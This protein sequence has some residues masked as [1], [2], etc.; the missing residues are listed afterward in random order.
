ME[1][2]GFTLDRFQEEAIGHLENDRSVLVAA[3]TGTGKTVV[4][5]WAVDEALRTGRRVIY[6]APIKALS[7]QKFRDYGRLHGTENVGLVTGDLVINRD[8]PC[9]VMTTEILRNM[10]LGGDD[11]EDLFAVVLDEVHFLDDR[12]RGT[13]WEEVLIYLPQRVLIVAL[14]A[15]LPNLDD[16]SRW[17]SYVRG[18]PTEVVIENERAVPLAFHVVTHGRDLMSLDEFD[19][20]ARRQQQN[21]RRE[22]DRRGSGRGRGRGR[23]QR[24]DRK[25]RKR[26]RGP[27]THPTEA[28]AHVRDRG[29]FPTLYFVF[30]RKDAERFAKSL[31]WRYRAEL[32]DQDEI[33][34]VDA[35]IATET[36]GEKLDPAMHDMYRRGIAFHH[37]GLHVHLK[38]LV[39]E[40][41]EQRLIK[42]LFCTS[43]FALGI[44][45][46]ARSVVF[47]GLHK[48]DGES[49]KPLPTRGFMQKA[50][51]AGRRGLDE[52]GH[53]VI[54]VDADD[55]DEARPL[56]KRYRSGR[57][58]PVRSR[59]S[60]SWNSIVALLERHDLD[61]IREVVD[62]SFL[63]WHRR[64]KAAEQVVTA[65]ELEST[66][67]G[68]KPSKR[69]LK[70]ARR[71]RRRAE[72]AED[73][74]W[75]EFLRK[76]DFLVEIG[77]LGP[78]HEFRAGARALR[79]LQIAELF[80][81]ELIL[82][83]VFHDLDNPTLFGLLCALTNDVPRAVT[84]DARLDRKDREL[85]LRV[86]PIRMGAAV[87]GGERIARQPVTW[88]AELIPVG[89]AWAD[90]WEFERVMT[91]VMSESDWSGALINGFRRAKDLL[92]QLRD[93]FEDDPTMNDRLRELHK[94]VARD[95]VQ[96]VG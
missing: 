92:G 9:L 93:V 7:N 1:Y 61:H 20:W 79:H 14:S 48:F 8:A 19:T 94:A 63:A 84:I 70:E 37:A 36:A 18:R 6:T 39:E 80:V 77:Y 78:D 5:D 15:T 75:E 44:N 27:R 50:G 89:R 24:F 81:A 41:Y 65:D 56:L 2:R 45:M 25:E 16:F 43:T 3:P 82:D 73:A 57:Y 74:C 42:V 59:F 26:R 35:H 88:S 67:N 83:G 72:E 96:V 52:H 4:A 64:H 33:D 23:G 55:A 17:L 34:A 29:G 53:V 47:H 28:L 66:D 38:T 91:L 54:R 76:R 71:L 87:S 12:E 32:L 69:D 49:V 85:A 31:A 60:L 10:L 68:R 13:V 95:E 22:D 58:E 46:P 51:R 86:N 40:L 62:K 21:A 90:G 30:S 11:V